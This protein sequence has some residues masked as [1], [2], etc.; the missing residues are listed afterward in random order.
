MQ[1]PHP[2]DCPG[3]Y[4][5]GAT[6]LPYNDDE[7]HKKLSVIQERLQEWSVEWATLEKQLSD[8]EKQKI[9]A[10]LEGYCLQDDWNSLV[11]RLPS[12][13]SELLPLI[14]SQALVTKDIFENVIEDPFF[15]LNRNENGVQ[16]TGEHGQ[17]FTP[18][19]VELHNL[20]KWCKQGMLCYLDQ[21]YVHTL[22]LNIVEPAAERERWNSRKWL[23]ITVRFLNAFTPETTFD[24]LLAMHMKR[25]RDSTLE[26]LVSNLLDESALFHPLL[27]TVSNSAKDRR[28]QDLLHVYQIAADLCIGM[29]TNEMD[30]E[31]GSFD[32]LGAF[33]ED[34]PH[35]EKHSYAEHETEKCDPSDKG[36][37]VLFMLQPTLTRYCRDDGEDDQSLIHRAVVIFSKEAA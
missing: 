17:V 36:R 10:G 31:F 5:R 4:L 35:M 6:W 14:L 28:Y 1:Y 34:V 11:E 15:Y 23:Q 12:N 19:H 13:I 27:K 2:A 29:W 33:H 3:Y 37:A 9:I 21:R 18:S 20:W 16:V 25:L 32:S 7:I 22:T 24:P 8:E 30:F 26:R